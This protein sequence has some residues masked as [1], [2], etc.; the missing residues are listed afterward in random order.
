[1]RRQIKKLT[2]VEIDATLAI[3]LARRL[4]ET[5]VTVLQQDATALQITAASFDGAVCLTM[6]HHVS[7]PEL[8]DRLLSEVARVLRPGA[9]FIGCDW[10]FRSRFDLTHLFDT[11]VPILPERFPARLR[12]AGFKDIRIDICRHAFRLHAR[13]A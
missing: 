3:S 10:L 13:K 6:L 7:S 2:A 9:S 1:M 12:S 8:Q 4:A 11:K 5:N